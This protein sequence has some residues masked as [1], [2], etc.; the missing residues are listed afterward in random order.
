MVYFRFDSVIRGHHI[1]K[2]IWTP[3][4]AETLHV[5]REA[6]YPEDCFTVAIVKDGTIIGHAPHNFSRIVWYFIEHDGTVSCQVTEHRK[7]GIG[8]E[9]LYCYT[10]SVK[11]NAMNAVESL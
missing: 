3:F 5:E 6:H 4:V 1:Y 8:L 2:D 9:T 10:F 7:F 11:K